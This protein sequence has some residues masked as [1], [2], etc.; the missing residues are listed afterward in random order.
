MSFCV[1]YKENNAI[2]KEKEKQ[3][4]QVRKFQVIKEQENSKNTQKRLWRITE[5]SEPQNFVFLHFII[6]DNCI[7]NHHLHLHHGITPG[8]LLWEQNIWF[9]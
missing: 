9:L 8:L 4:M 6:I 3:T 5:F 2:W 1:K 7:P